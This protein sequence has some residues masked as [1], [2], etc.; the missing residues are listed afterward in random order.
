MRA[1]YGETFCPKVS[2]RIPTLQCLNQPTKVECLRQL[3]KAVKEGVR[4]GNEFVKQNKRGLINL[5]NEMIEEQKIPDKDWL[6]LCLAAVAEP[7]CEVFLP[8][9][10]Q[11]KADPHQRSQ[12][13]IDNNDAF[14]DG[15]TKVSLTHICIVSDICTYLLTNIL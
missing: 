10:V 7:D 6:L 1:R 14:W 2:H 5:V 12:V 4:N 11:Q 13:L 15:V 8:G 9:Y 3:H